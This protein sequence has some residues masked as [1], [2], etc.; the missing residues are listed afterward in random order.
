[1][2]VLCVRGLDHPQSTPFPSKAGYRLRVPVG[3]SFVFQPL[4]LPWVTGSMNGSH[5]QVSIVQSTLLLELLDKRKRS[6]TFLVWITSDFTKLSN[7]WFIKRQSRGLTFFYIIY[8]FSLCMHVCV[9]IPA[10]HTTM[11]LCSK[12]S[13]E[14]LVFLPPCES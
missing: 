14:E 1:M 13:L 6:A 9:C 3:L 7:I 2:P 12:D 10:A 11:Y 8:L 5:W 4:W